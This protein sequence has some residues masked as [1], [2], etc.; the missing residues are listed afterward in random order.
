MGVDVFYLAATEACLEGGD[1]GVAVIWLT[2]WCDTPE[3][4]TWNA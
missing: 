3:I 1:A 4:V 2:S